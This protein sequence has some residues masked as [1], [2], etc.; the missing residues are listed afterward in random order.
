MKTLS[1][2]LLIVTIG[3][4]SMSAQAQ[5][6]GVEKFGLYVVASDLDAARKFYE[7]LFQKPP[8]VTNDKL[9]GFDVAG[10][11]Y[12]VFAAQAADR[13]IDKGNSAVPYLR[14]KDAEREFARL[15]L[16]DVTM[17]DKQVVQEG[18]LKLFRI[19]DLDGNVIEFF[20]LVAVSK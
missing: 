15:R 9:V 10:G 5:D 1:R 13:K 16:L 17:L 20:S 4:I 12:A 2:F 8:Y 7:R 18:P 6:S 19:A 11:L 14:V 3:L